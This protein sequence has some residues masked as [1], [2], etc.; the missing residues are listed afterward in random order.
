MEWNSYN[1]NEW[2]VDDINSGQYAAFV[3]LITFDNG[4]FILA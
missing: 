4:D 3:Y 2:K 1:E